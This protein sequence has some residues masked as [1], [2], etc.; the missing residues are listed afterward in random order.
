MCAPSIE[1]QLIKSRTQIT[2]I[3]FQLPSGLANG[4]LFTFVQRQ[5]SGTA[6]N[7]AYLSGFQTALQL[8]SVSI[9]LTVG[10]GIS[11]VLVHPIPSRRR[12][13]GMFSL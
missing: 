13:A 5:E 6:T 4:G 11:L 8:I 1:F 7:E 12:A 10:L 9:G 2:G 3:L